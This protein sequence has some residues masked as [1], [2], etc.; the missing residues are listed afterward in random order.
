MVTT[1]SGSN[2]LHGT[3]FE[4]LR[5]TD[6]DARSFFA[7]TTEKFNLNQF[8]FSAGGPIRKD[9]TFFFGT[10]EAQKYTLAA[11]FLTTEPSL[12]YQQ[13]ALG[14]LKQYGVPVNSVS[15]NMLNTFWPAESER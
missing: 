13:G 7:T 5:N 6:L 12:A 4:F 3:L 2:Q 15:V 9:K 8:G 11:G 14:L 10:Y 1:K